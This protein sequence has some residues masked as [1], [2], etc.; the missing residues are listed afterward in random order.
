MT[1]KV[2]GSNPAPAG[3]GEFE[4]EPSDPVAAT[5]TTAN[6]TSDTIVVSA[7]PRRRR[8][9]APNARG[10][11]SPQARRAHHGVAHWERRGSEQDTPRRVALVRHVTRRRVG[12]PLLEGVTA[13]HWVV[14]QRAPAVNPDL[15]T[16]DHLG[17]LRHTVHPVPRSRCEGP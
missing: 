10:T 12:E 2:A 11:P 17:G 5:V 16:P 6:T 4:D 1:L 9:T 3:V 14:S 13:T 8:R 7:S 15:S